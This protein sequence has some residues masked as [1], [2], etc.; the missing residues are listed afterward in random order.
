MFQFYFIVCMLS[1]LTISS[2]KYCNLYKPYN[3]R[4]LSMK[5]DEI[6]NENI[7]GR[8]CNINTINSDYRNHHIK[9][10]N[11]LTLSA[12]LIGI[13]LL[14]PKTTIADEDISK[15]LIQFNGESFPLKNYLGEKCTLVVNVASQCALT[16]QYEGLV[17]LYNT[18]HSKGMNIIA[19]PCNQFGSQ[20]PSS[21][22]KIR[23]DMKRQ[24]N[25]EFPI[26]D[27]IDVN[28]PY[29]HPLY[30]K[31]KSYQDIGVSNISKISWNFEKFLLDSNGIPIR[32]YKPG[33]EPEYIQND[34]DSYIKTSILIPRKKPTLNDY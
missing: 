30:S 33:F 25:V 16:P 31:L 24:Y 26:M 1:Y 5:N 9:L 6:S 3:N 20:E 34:I 29:T 12:T 10:I 19:F 2:L 32:R 27:K 23:I 18:Y 13:S 11:K 7:N 17:T 28:G 14:T 4:L 22:D 21:V 15:I 8:Y